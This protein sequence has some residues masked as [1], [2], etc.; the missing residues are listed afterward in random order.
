MIFRKKLVTFWQISTLEPSSDCFH[1]IVSAPCP[2]ILMP[3]TDFPSPEYLIFCTQYLDMNCFLTTLCPLFFLMLH[4]FPLHFYS[5]PSLSYN[6]SFLCLPETCHPCIVNLQYK[7]DWTNKHMVS[8]LYIFWKA[9][10]YLGHY[11]VSKLKGPLLYYWHFPNLNKRREFKLVNEVSPSIALTKTV[12]SNAIGW[13]SVRWSLTLSLFFVI[14]H[15][16]YQYCK[17]F[18]ILFWLLSIYSKHSSFF[19]IFIHININSEIC[20]PFSMFA[21]GCYILRKTYQP[22][23]LFLPRE[24]H[25]WRVLADPSP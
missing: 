6:I 18:T 7:G 14:L 23:P 22:I 21:E 8:T 5:T 20:N 12:N 24:F 25:G 19:N 4:Y 3:S 11:Q 1:D 16:C 17:Y 15:K 10:I 13:L 9:S 2:Y